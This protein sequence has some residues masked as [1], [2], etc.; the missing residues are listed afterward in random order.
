[1]KR[2]LVIAVKLSCI[3]LV[4]TPSTAQGGS[5]GGSGGFGGMSCSGTVSASCLVDPRT[6]TGE[7]AATECHPVGVETICVAA[8]DTLGL[9]SCA[10]GRPK[11]SCV[12]AAAVC[13]TCPHDGCPSA[14]AP[15]SLASGNT[16]IRQ[17]DIK[18]LPGLGS[19]VGLSHAW[20]SLW[21]QTQSTFSTGIFG[22]N[23]R[24]TYE[25][26][27]FMGSDGYI[28]YARRRQLLVFRF[29]RDRNQAGRTFDCG[30]VAILH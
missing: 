9:G 22:V 27:V 21:P 10:C 30:C 1:M 25:E 18:Q 6:A 19:G 23:W 14:G 12:P 13:E 16:Y 20:N 26:R 29:R 8:G 17:T 28:K 2:L 7:G 24:S 11:A 3:L 5:S 4:A 15:I